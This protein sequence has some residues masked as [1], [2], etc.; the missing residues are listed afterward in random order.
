MVV[1]DAEWQAGQVDGASGAEGARA[2]KSLLELKEVTEAFPAVV[3][4]P[5]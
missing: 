5:E 4:R 1:I 3:E 2:P